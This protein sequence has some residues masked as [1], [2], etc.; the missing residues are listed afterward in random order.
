MM[1]LRNY[2]EVQYNSKKAQERQDQPSPGSQLPGR[3]VEARIHI[4]AQ[5]S[6]G[7]TGSELP[8]QRPRDNTHPRFGL[9]GTIPLD[10]RGTDRANH[11]LWF[12]IAFTLFALLVSLAQHDHVF[13]IVRPINPQAGAGFTNPR[14]HIPITVPIAYRIKPWPYQRRAE[15]CIGLARQLLPGRTV[16]LP[17]M[18]KHLFLDA[19]LIRSNPLELQ[20]KDEGENDRDGDGEA[21]DD[22]NMVIHSR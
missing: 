14:N 10:R 22:G 11:P 18:G 21:N 20:P 19:L 17:T 4:K 1:I 2:K 3:W 9:S 15:E 16:I 5:A 6:T 8:F 7:C 12:Q 13:V